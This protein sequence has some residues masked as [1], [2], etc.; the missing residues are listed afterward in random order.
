MIAKPP[1]IDWGSGKVARLKWRAH[2]PVADWARAYIQH[3]SSVDT[4]M[5][6]AMAGMHMR[7]RLQHAE[8]LAVLRRLEAELAQMAEL[9]K[10]RG[11]DGSPQ[12]ERRRGGA[13]SSP[14]RPADARPSPGE[15]RQL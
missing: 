14:V 7:L 10:I 13:R 4:E 12:R 15:Q 1:A 2:R 11:Q 5:Q 3:Q 9:A 6:R 8:T